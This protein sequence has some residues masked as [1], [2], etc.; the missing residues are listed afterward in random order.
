[1]ERDDLYG[2][3]FNIGSQEEITISGLAD[4]RSATWSARTPRSRYVPYDEAYEEGFEDMQRRVPDISKIQPVLGW[5]PTR[6]S[7]RS[8]STS[9]TQ[10]LEST[11]LS[12]VA[13]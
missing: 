12:A 3:V 13:A 7:T 9:R 4:A 10:Q 6:S 5:A 1:M 11:R 8:C 2:E